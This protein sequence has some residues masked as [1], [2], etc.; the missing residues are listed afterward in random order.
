[1]KIGIITSTNYKQQNPTFCSQ[2]VMNVPAEIAP[3]LKEYS[4]QHLIKLIQKHTSVELEPELGNILSKVVGE[5]G[6]NDVFLNSEESKKM[7][8]G[9]L[10]VIN[11][12]PAGVS[13]DEWAKTVHESI[14]PPLNELVDKAEIFKSSEFGKLNTNLINEAKRIAD[15]EAMQESLKNLISDLSGKIHERR[16]S[17]SNLKNVIGKFKP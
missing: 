3:E 13:G 12:K 4:V 15:F 9:F 5:E 11:P 7:S 14:I 6:C 16:I 1:M 10:N 17:I 2:K 8:R